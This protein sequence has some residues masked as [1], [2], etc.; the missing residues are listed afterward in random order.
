MERDDFVKFMIEELKRQQESS[1]FDAP[2]EATAE[3]VYQKLCYDFPTVTGEE[4]GI[5]TAA[6]E[7]SLVG[8]EQVLPVVLHAK[9]LENL[10]YLCGSPQAEADRD[11][12]RS[13]GL[14]CAAVFLKLPAHLLASRQPAL[15]RAFTDFSFL[16]PDEEAPDAH[17]PTPAAPAATWATIS[18]RFR[19][20]VTSA[21]ASSICA[22]MVTP[23]GVT[24]RLTGGSRS[25]LMAGG[26]VDALCA[27]IRLLGASA[28]ELPVSTGASVPADTLGAYLSRPSG[29]HALGE[30]AE[31]EGGADSRGAVCKE[32]WTHLVFLCRDVTIHSP[33][34]V[35][36]GSFAAVCSAVLWP[37][38][39][40]TETAAAAGGA[41]GTGG[42]SAFPSSPECL[43]VLLFA[44]ISASIRHTTLASHAPAPT[45]TL[46][47]L[48]TPP[49]PAPTT[50][51]LPTE[52]G[53][54][55]SPAAGGGVTLD[56]SSPGP[57]GESDHVARLKAHQMRLAAKGSLRAAL[58]RQAEGGAWLERCVDICARMA[59]HSLDGGAEAA[60]LLAD[61]CE[62]YLVG[63]ERR[64][65]MHE[66]L[67]VSRAL[68]FLVETLV[69]ALGAEP[70]SGPG[71]GA[72]V[73]LR[74][75]SGQLLETISRV[76]LQSSATGHFLLRLP[77]FLPAVLAAAGSAG[78]PGAFEPALV[79]PLLLAL[80]N[81][82]HAS[83]VQ[84]GAYE[85][86]RGLLVR[87]LDLISRGVAAN[88]ADGGEGDEDEEDEVEGAALRA[89]MAALGLGQAGAGA[90]GPEAEG[91]EAV[92]DAAAPRKARL[93][94]GLIP[95]LVLL[96]DAGAAGVCALAGR[97]AVVSSALTGWVEGLLRA[98]DERRGAGR[99]RL[100]DVRRLAKA[101]KALLEGRSNKTD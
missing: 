66:R 59:V 91:Q 95:C 61:V 21:T 96:G 76:A 24:G 100:D 70:G 51:T 32:A 15:E 1:L 28:A 13:A 50:P 80:L 11:F 72:A 2:R 41:A 86:L 63:G 84:G 38:H 97:D 39:G 55:S 9:F 98:A 7:A 34:L 44:S 26:H 4:I 6:I 83:A 99:S 89:R 18:A 36:D 75:V 25:A 52:P 23:A 58:D 17:A 3:E 20:F 31:D 65:S 62:L 46:P 77:G 90:E 93:P 82:S 30:G 60:A 16:P 53:P 19:A 8:S 92:A 49:A 37:H 48:P 87:A 71:V 74:A 56:T 73:P 27:A 88:V 68:V 12:A 94:A 45:P 67:I 85:A 40:G 47:P 54:S 78:T 29:A 33:E 57:L 42:G 5:L 22:G 101:L 81:A 14:L 35:V 69:R 10:H 43:F 64:E 79:L